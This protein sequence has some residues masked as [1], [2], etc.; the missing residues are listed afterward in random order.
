MIIKSETSGPCPWSPFY[1]PQEFSFVFNKSTVTLNHTSG[2]SVKMFLERVDGDGKTYSEYRWHRLN[3]L[4]SW[5][6]LKRV[7]ER[8]SCA[9]A[10][11]APCFLLLWP[12]EELPHALLHRCS[13]GQHPQAMSYFF[14]LILSLEEGKK[15]AAGSFTL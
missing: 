6:E 15:E 11:M 2:I 12:G 9:A 7:K 10:R 4:G 14:S 5:T 13:C 1:S 8:V 3:K